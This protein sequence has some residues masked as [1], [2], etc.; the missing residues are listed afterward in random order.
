LKDRNSC[1]SL[2]LW[3]LRQCRRIVRIRVTVD[4]TTVSSHT[5]SPAAGVVIRTC[6]YATAES[7]V[8]CNSDGQSSP[9]NHGSQRRFNSSWLHATHPYC[10]GNQRAVVI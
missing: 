2:A 8:G 10:P 4:R 5:M 9:L 3:E 1:V 6:C 7:S